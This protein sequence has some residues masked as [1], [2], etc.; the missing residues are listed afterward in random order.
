MILN[1]FGSRPT[2]YR[3]SSC[4]TPR[5][6]STTLGSKPRGTASSPALS[7]RSSL[8]ACAQAAGM[9]AMLVPALK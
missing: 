6:T 4:P 3:R 7:D 2:V 1:A 8:G 9:H 5:Y